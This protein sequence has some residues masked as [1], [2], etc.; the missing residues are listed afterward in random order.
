MADSSSSLEGDWGI[1]S[2]S[3]VFSQPKAET[4]SSHLTLPAVFLLSFPNFLS[5]YFKISADR[6]FQTL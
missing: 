2:R 4:F 3:S 5:F 1:Q 6:I